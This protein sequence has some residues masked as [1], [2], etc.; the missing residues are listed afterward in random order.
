M[1]SAVDDE[2]VA[3]AHTARLTAPSSVLSVTGST[4]G[5]RVACHV[6]AKTVMPSH[7]MAVSITGCAVEPPFCTNATLVASNGSRAIAG[8]D[9][10]RMIGLIEL[11]MSHHLSCEPS[12]G[13]TMASTL[14]SS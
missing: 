8:T 6:V 1:T 4:P 12:L 7:G 10:P 13:S 11:V 3:C 5:G 2:V 14:I 9:E